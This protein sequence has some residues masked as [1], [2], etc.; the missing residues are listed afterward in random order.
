MSENLMVKVNSYDEE[1]NK[2][3]K[4]CWNKSQNINDLGIDTTRCRFKTYL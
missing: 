1:F 3:V 2:I 4:S